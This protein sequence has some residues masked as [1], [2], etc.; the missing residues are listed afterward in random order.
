M[1]QANTV[2]DT[3][4]PN[5]SREHVRLQVGG[6]PVEVVRLHGHEKLGQMFRYDL[7]CRAKAT[8]SSPKAL[9][10]QPAVVDLTD[11][12]GS[13]RFVQG[14]VAKA[15]RRVR[16]DGSATL[17]LVVRPR[18]FPLSLGR[19]SRVFNDMTVPQIVEKVLEHT[20]APHRM[21]LTRSYQTRVYTAQY[22]ED[23]WV[24]IQRLCEE[25]GI[26]IWFDHAGD[27]TL[28]FSDDSTAA[29]AIEGG[30]LLE[31][32]LE[33]GMTDAKEHIHELASEAHATATKFTVGSFDPERPALKV[34]ATEGDGVHEMYDAPGGG[35]VDPAEC[36][37]RAS[38]RLEAAKAFRAGVSGNATS[39]RL[40]PGKVMAV[41]GHPALDDS[42]YLTET[43]LT[44]TQDARFAEARE[45]QFLC[46]FEAIHQKVPFRPQEVSPKST[47]AGIQSGRVTG[48]PGEEIH[49]DGR[50]CVRVQLHWDREGAWDHQAGKWMRVAQR[51]TASSMLYPRIGWNVMT[52]MEEGN[53]DAPAVLSRVHDADHPPTYDLPG[54][55][56]RTVFR[57]LTSPSDAT[58]NE[59]RFEDLTGSE[60]MFLNATRDMNFLTKYSQGLD[61]K[62]DHSRTVG[63]NQQVQVAS[64]YT[65][66][67]GNDQSWSVGGDQKIAV[68][69]HRNQDVDG[70]ETR[71]IG[72]NRKVEVGS[73][74]AIKVTET[75][76][77]EVG[78][79][80]QEK[81]KSNFS[82][83]AADA[84]LEVGG[85]MMLD[86]QRMINVSVGEGIDQQ[87]GGSK[88]EIL[89]ADNPLTVNEKCTVKI[90]ASYL[91]ST[92]DVFMDGSKYLTNWQVQSAVEG[93]APHVHIE[94]QDK[95]ELKCGASTICVDKTSVTIRTPNY[96][97][98][99]AQLVSD[100][101]IIN[102]N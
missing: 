88:L 56:T 41:S 35:P 60:E 79:S 25:E 15:E 39:I 55:K 61:V 17:T 29:P 27:T 44:I 45:D 43:V 48:P 92:K 72:G 93:K 95:I 3:I 6:Q 47:Q 46:H 58:A 63:N 16:D 99:G 54:N 77:L 98:S 102:H 69:G 66:G 26:T 5:L 78:G 68:T 57:T 23:D 74:A 32:A 1:S 101:S 18:A 89:G 76:K 21:A 14:L 22:R 31:F 10:G 24:F 70:N 12:A 8:D 91:M 97:L 30:P 84:K 86:T 38:D 42:Y 34:M 100:T 11:H 51:G 53:V 71:T 50:G 33:R 59:I 75:R 40:V 19:D 2:I 96:D 90:G 20:T 37:R 49:T 73:N 28:V 64:G 85:S 82:F 62:H 83:A 67:V 36:H 87:I 52:F 65:E 7:T 80:L 13:V 81:T 4:T 9:I 94:A